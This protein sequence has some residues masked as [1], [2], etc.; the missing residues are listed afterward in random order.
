VRLA[1]PADAVV[2]GDTPFDIACARAAG[3]R[4]VAVATGAYPLD[5]L[6]EL[7]PDLAVETLDDLGVVLP[8]IT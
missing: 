6:Q 7:E 4:V 2:I 3:A 1:D 5:E 8:V